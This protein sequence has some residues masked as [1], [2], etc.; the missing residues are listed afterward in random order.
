MIEV[1]ANTGG[2]VIVNGSDVGQM[3]NE[4]DR[5]TAERDAL[6]S[7][8][9]QLEDKL[10]KAIDLDFQRRETIEQ[11]QGRIAELESGRGMPVA[12]V[13]TCDD[14]VCYEADDGVVISNTPGDET[15]LYKWK[16]VYFGSQPAPVSAALPDRKEYVHKGL[17]HTD[18]RTDGWNACL[19]AVTRLND[20]NQ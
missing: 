4:L 14:E 12:Y 11:L 7:T 13:L 8:I 3:K 17:S 19:D 6:Q 18:A 1:K 20:I 15:N 9:A 10:N 5:V 2:K 16:P